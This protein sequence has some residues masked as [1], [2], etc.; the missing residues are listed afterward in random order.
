LLLQQV[1]QQLLALMPTIMP[2]IKRRNADHSKSMVPKDISLVVVLQT[3]G[4][5]SKKYSQ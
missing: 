3:G 4:S 5:F 1:Y 2:T